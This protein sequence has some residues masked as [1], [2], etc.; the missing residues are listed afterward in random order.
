M[1]RKESKLENTIKIRYCQ[2]CNRP[3]KYT[4]MRGFIQANENNSKCKKCAIKGR[5][6]SNAHKRKISKSLLNHRVSKKTKKKQSLAHLGKPGYWKGKKI[7]SNARQK[8]RETALNRVY[9]RYNPNACKIIDDY[10]KK[11]GYMFQ[12]ALNGG[13]FRVTGY[14][15][16]GYDAKKNVVIEYYENHHKKQWRKDLIRQRRIMKHLK[17]KFIVI[18]EWKLK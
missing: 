4:T 15:V 13:E 7:P 12:H 2:R 11:Y 6:M 9:P 3:I 10:G 17:C 16:D 18:K 1:V 5:L 8:M 14:A